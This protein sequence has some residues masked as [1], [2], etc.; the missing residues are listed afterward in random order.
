MNCHNSGRSQF[1]RSSNNNYR[2]ISPSSTSYNILTN[3]LPSRLT[4]YV[5]EITQDHQY[6]LRNKRSVII[7]TLC[8]RQISEKKW[9]YNGRVQQLLVCFKKAYRRNY[10]KMEGNT[11]EHSR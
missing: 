9:E 11:V 8:I 4:P 10:I 5:D 1:T 6:R 3:I 7:Q 2:G